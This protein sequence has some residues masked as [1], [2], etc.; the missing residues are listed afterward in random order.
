M[1]NIYQH[2]LNLNPADLK[3][4]RDMFFL[5]FGVAET[6]LQNFL[7]ENAQPRNRYVKFFSILFDLKENLSP[8]VMAVPLSR[9]YRAFEYK[10]YKN[11]AKVKSEK[12][13]GVIGKPLSFGNTPPKTKERT[14]K[15]SVAEAKPSSGLREQAK[16]N[17]AANREERAAQKQRQTEHDAQYR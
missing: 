12:I 9:E 11:E 7:Q 5:E 4:I 8:I 16:R 15:V 14:A 10:E 17:L 13:F 2:Y 1:T 6:T 3:R